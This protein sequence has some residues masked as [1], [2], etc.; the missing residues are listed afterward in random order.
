M[1]LSTSSAQADFFSS[2]SLVG[3]VTTLLTV[4]Q[5]R[6]SFVGTPQLKQDLSQL[7]R[8]TLLA[9]RLDGLAFLGF[10]SRNVLNISSEFW[11]Q[12]RGE[13]AGLG[14]AGDLTRQFV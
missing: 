7:L 3:M 2:N 11:L 5:E 14:S 6:S 4:I 10:D 8:A 1:A 9:W 13:R 12:L